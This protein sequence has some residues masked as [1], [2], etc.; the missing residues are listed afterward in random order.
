MRRIEKEK[1]NQDKKRKEEKIKIILEINNTI[2]E[3][4]SAIDKIIIQLIQ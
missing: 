1:K 2:K 3:R 4:K